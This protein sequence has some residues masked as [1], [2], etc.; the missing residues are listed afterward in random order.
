MNLA[1]G[2]IAYNEI[3]G[4]NQQIAPQETGKRHL[5]CGQERQLFVFVNICDNFCCRECRVVVVV[6][7]L[8][9][10]REAT[11]W[12]WQGSQ[13]SFLDRI[14]VVRWVH[15]GSSADASHVSCHMSEIL[16][17]C[18]DSSLEGCAVLFGSVQV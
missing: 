11:V 14:Q 4:L 1:P 2:C 9:D 12:S 16:A 10:G 6:Q 17:V 7:I 15:V 5:F 13:G 3:A 18:R 8:G